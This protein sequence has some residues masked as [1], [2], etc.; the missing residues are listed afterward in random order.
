MATGYVLT[1]GGT[2]EK[3]YSERMGTVQNL[4]SKT[5]GYL[6]L[7]RL[8][9]CELNVV[10]LINKD[11]PEMTDE[12]R[13]LIL[14]MVRATLKENASIAITHGTDAMVKTGLYLQ[15]A[16]PQLETP[17]VLTGAI[18]PLSFKRSDGCRI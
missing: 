15:R 2:I 4:N 6:R 9:N 1:T 7:S 17:I 12:D 10:P 13:I 3:A 8:P 16:L 14:G 11:S 18:T 5:E